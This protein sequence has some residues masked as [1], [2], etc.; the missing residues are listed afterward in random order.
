MSRR[1]QSK[2]DEGSKEE[3]RSKDDKKRS[4]NEAKLGEGR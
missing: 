4:R 2:E 1:E 3:R